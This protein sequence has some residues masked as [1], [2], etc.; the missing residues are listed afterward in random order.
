MRLSRFV[1]ALYRPPTIAVHNHASGILS[2]SRMAGQALLELLRAHNKNCTWGVGGWGLGVGGGGHTE[3]SGQNPHGSSTNCSTC[4]AASST[5]RPT[6]CVWHMPISRV[7]C[8]A[9]HVHRTTCMHVAA[10]TPSPRW[11]VTH[12]IM[13]KNIEGMLVLCLAVQRLLRGN[14]P[15]VPS[16][17]SLLLW[18]GCRPKYMRNSHV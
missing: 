11:R 17:R 2:A 13:K 6:F 8:L 12:R 15:Q 9:V 3:L 14:S 1:L 10:W 16:S 4:Y 5:W 7:C 18:A